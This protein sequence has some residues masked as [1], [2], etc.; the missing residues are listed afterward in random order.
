VT[1]SNS[2]NPAFAAF[3]FQYAS[4]SLQPLDLNYGTSEGNST[5]NFPKAEFATFSTGA[6]LPA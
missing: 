6:T 5:L 1:E 4:F 3:F 2:Q